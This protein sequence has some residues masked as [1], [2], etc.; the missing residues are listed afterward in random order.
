M[1]KVLKLMPEYE[2]YPI[3]ISDNGGIFKN[4]P[5]SNLNI[6][7]DLLNKITYW[8]KIYEDAYNRLNPIASGI[9][10]EQLILFKKQGMEI[11]VQLLLELPDHEIIYV[12]QNDIS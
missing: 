7:E 10:E 1:K 6:S 8:D 5:P 9:K 12:Y 3:W 4:I 11:Y 2:C